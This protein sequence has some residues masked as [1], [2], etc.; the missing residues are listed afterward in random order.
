M[1]V[2]ELVRSID[3]VDFISQ[4]VD[5]EQRGDEF[6]GIS[7]FTFPPEH[8]PSFSVRPEPPV[9]YDYS[10]GKGGNVYS[11]IKELKKCTPREAVDVL[12]E[13]AGYDGEVEINHERMAATLTCR[14]FRDRPKQ[15][16]ASTA[17]K[18]DDNYMDKYEDN[19]LKTNLWYEE[20]I[21]YESMEKF[22]VRY[23]P[24]SNRIVYPIR[25]PDG[26]IVNIG[27][28]ALDFDWKER[29]ERKY[30][31]FF[32]W[33]TIDTIYGISENMD[34]IQKSKEIILF[35]GCKSVL[36]A[37]TWGIHNTAAILTS[38]LSTNQFKI[39]IKLGYD[40]V[41]ALD[42]DVNVLL[43]KNIQKLKQ[44]IGVYYI[45]DRQGLLDSKDSPVD[46]GAE[47]F[48]QLFD[49]RKRL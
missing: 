19:K 46:K 13:F 49:N 1:D 31:Y 36:I 22:Q 45:Q 14:L 10:S 17:T 26:E 12:K 42:K 41:F 30:T 18:L 40:V 20:G 35:E 23:D 34:G 24:F 25:N 48:K 11:F 28:R 6:W 44:Y 27:G 2:E 16:K 8:T 3:I 33:G 43:D 5:L 29:G 4:Y 9:F 37:D 32:K 38:H 15:G 47:V 7:P 39:L 21:S